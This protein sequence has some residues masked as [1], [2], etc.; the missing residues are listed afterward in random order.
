V[1]VVWYQVAAEVRSEQS[2][3]VQLAK[4]RQKFAL[5]LSEKGL[6]DGNSCQDRRRG[7]L[8]VTVGQVKS[9]LSKTLLLRRTLGK[10]R[11]YFEAGVHSTSLRR[12]ALKPNHTTV[13]AVG[14]PIANGKMPPG[15]SLVC[16]LTVR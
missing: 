16:G 15:L 2:L 14:V 1:F 4:V 6:L 10:C 12:I 11:I 9:T 7:S 3:R 5:I 13:K 8:T